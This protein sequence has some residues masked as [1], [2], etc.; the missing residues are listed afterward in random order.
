MYLFLTTIQQNQTWTIFEGKT[1][2]STKIIKSRKAAGLNKIL[3]KVW[4][5]RKFDNILLW[6][7]N[8]KT[9]GRLHSPLPKIGNLGIFKNYTSII[10]TAIVAKVYNTLL[11]NQI[12]IE[13]K[14]ILRKNQ[15]GFRRNQS[16][17]SQILTIHQI[18]KGVCGKKSRGN[19]IVSRFLKSIWFHIQREYSANTTSIWYP[20][21]NKLL[22]L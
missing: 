22:Q 3:P 8:R 17:S 18:I 19:I 12:W 6:L 5:T 10:L 9:D 1:W 4:K 11:L 7:C 14:K 21:K 20:E 2:C 16:R 13:A 15:N